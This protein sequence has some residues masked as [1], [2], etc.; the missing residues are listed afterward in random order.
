ADSLMHM[1]QELNSFYG[2]GIDDDYSSWSNSYLYSRIYN[3]FR[4]LKDGSGDL[5]LTDIL[6]AENQGR[7][8]RNRTFQV[9][10]SE[11]T[12]YWLKLRFHNQTG[13]DGEFPTMLGKDESTWDTIHV[14][15]ALRG[16]GFDTLLYG[17]Y[18][19][20]EDKAFEDWRNIY[21][22][23]L[24]KDSSELVYIRLKGLSQFNQP[25]SIYLLNLKESFFSKEEPRALRNLA[26]FMGILIFQ[27]FYYLLLLFSSADRTYIPYLVY[28]V[29][30][31]LFAVTGYFFNRW[32]PKYGE[33]EWFAYFL[34]FWVASAGLLWFSLRFLNIAE[35]SLRWSKIT[36]WYIWVIAIP[37]AFMI[38][39]IGTGNW[40]NNTL[41]EDMVNELADLAV[42]AMFLTSTL[43][44]VL[45]IFLGVLAYRK[46]NRLAVFYLIAIICLMLGI[47][48]TPMMVLLDEFLLTFDQAVL[49]A[50]IGVVAQL[51]VF[52]LGV[53]YKR[54]IVDQEREQA[55]K[56]NLEAQ[57]AIN[58]K[59]RQADKLK[60]E[61]LANTSHELRTPLNGI[62]GITESLMDGVAGELNGDM[63]ENLGMIVSSGKRLS[64][65]VNDILDFSKLKNYELE[66]QTKPID[67]R[68]LVKVVLRISQQ[69]VVNKELTLVNELPE[70]L[71]PVYADENRLQQILYNLIGNA[72]K[73]TEEGKVI[74]NAEERDGMMYVSVT[75]SGIG[76]PKD[77]QARI[78]ESFEQGDGSTAR[79]FGGT[80]L[81]LSI[82]RQLVELHGGRISVES[83]P[84]QG[85]R[86]T[87]S[88]PLSKSAPLPAQESDV[89]GGLREDFAS[90]MPVTV[91]ETKKEAGENGVRKNNF[92]LSN[93]EIHILAVDDEPI[94]Q[95]VLK[96]HLSTE[97]YFVTTVMNGQ[98]ALEALER[99]EHFD[100]VLLDVMMPQMSGF[101][102]CQKIRERYLPSELPVIMLT[103]KNQ[104]ADLVQGLSQGANDYIVKPF[105]KQEL[106]ARIKTHLNLLRI[107]SATGRFV[108][109]EFLR[110]LGH[111]SILDVQLGD[112]VEQKV[113]VFFSDIR[114]YTTL[115]EQ[116]S[117]KENFNFLNAYLGRVGPIIKKQGG[118]VNQYYGDGIMALFP[119][120]T[121]DAVD[122]ALD[123]QRSIQTYNQERD[124]KG[125]LPI[126]L[127]IGL[128]S[129][130]VPRVRYDLLID[131]A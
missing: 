47:G 35:I 39:L 77:K 96:N 1:A 61:F 85:S 65:L 64:G 74:V 23:E 56:E 112:Q 62:I 6:Q 120:S 40:L 16:G 20:V 58:E 79:R 44:L 27:G 98:E 90:M 13:R 131:I 106:L 117:P 91:E 122:A 52:A 129:G 101:E 15:R 14:Y 75:D 113:T 72:I 82:T 104:V 128:H 43:S 48:V 80:G 68:A 63:K 42:S 51:A 99:G 12:V 36:K 19:D 37:P 18:V 34:A 107:N 57:N 3:S 126:R 100:L 41:G 97:E 53:G 31:S 124:K 4:I 45:I 26:I 11:D 8:Q 71:P 50:E 114:D 94:N 110:I 130:P 24:D 95:Q 21:W 103:A 102:V 49:T 76:I 55:L 109:Y 60:D 30:L 59:L 69:L 25:S 46:G 28:L 17:Q 73:F 127:G 119:Q 29:G 121:E 9:P 54:R 66:L 67:L 86:F 92:P 105:S 108:P 32:F 38:S 118:F 115:S 116:M 2:F 78:F 70:S 10:V 123:I 125:R 84:M 111:E 81:G 7:F 5:T 87:F 88:L 83:E 33:L 89:L 93:T 22:S